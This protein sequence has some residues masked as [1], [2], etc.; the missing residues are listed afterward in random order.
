MVLSPHGMS[1]WFEWDPPAS[2]AAIR[3]AER[4]N[5]GPLPA[6]YLELVRI[7]NGGSTQGNL[8]ILPVEDC[9]Q[10]NADYEVAEYMPGYFMIGDDGGGTAIVLNEQDGRIH[11]VSMG[12]MDEQFAQLSADSLE[13]FLELGTSLIER[14]EAG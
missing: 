3:E 4:E 13:E 5:G 6:A 11:E 9:V 14:G 2:D 12:V 1:K 7:H 10:R 8:S